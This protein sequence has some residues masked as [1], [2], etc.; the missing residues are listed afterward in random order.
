MGFN[1]PQDGQGSWRHVGRRVDQPLLCIFAKWSSKIKKEKTSPVVSSR[2]RCMEAWCFCTCKI[3]YLESHLQ[4]HQRKR[5]IKSV[6]KPP[7]LMHIIYISVL[8]KLPE[9]STCQEAGRSSRSSG[10]VLRELLQLF[11]PPLLCLV[12]VPHLRPRREQGEAV[13]PIRSRLLCDW[14]KT[15]QIIISLCWCMETVSIDFTVS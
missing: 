8:K 2:R 15:Q 5:D 1:K 3:Q 14:V 7:T 10:A 12:S 13:R 6:I 9:C 4:L 11:N